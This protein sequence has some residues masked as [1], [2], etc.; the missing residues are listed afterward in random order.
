MRKVGGHVSI[1]GGISN[2][3]INTLKIGGNCLQIF[4]GSPRLWSRQLWKEK[5]ATDFTNQIIEKN[6]NPVFIHALYLVNLASDKP[7]LLQKSTDSLIIDIKNGDQI[8]CAGV[9]VHIGSHQGRGFDSVKEQLVEALKTILA[10]TGKTPLLLETD[11][12]QNGKIGSIEELSYLIKAVDDPRLQ[13]C[14]DTAHLFEGGLD[15]RDK[16]V[17]NTFIQQLKDYKILDKV[18]CI[19]LNDS[20][21]E[22]DSH[23]DNHADLGKGKIGLDGLRN[24]VAHPDLIH[25]PLI[26]ETPGPDK[27]GPNSENVSIAKNL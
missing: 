1:G 18:S 19:H 20:A 13:I 6:L 23:R 21:T 25:L 5:E 12:G 26:L 7:D 27:M 9:I 22:L 8:N 17:V 15:M 14:F 11:A 3:V 4:A 16:K 10:S 24:F 2:A